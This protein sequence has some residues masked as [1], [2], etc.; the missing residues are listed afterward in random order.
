MV[1]MKGCMC[2]CVCERE[3]EREGVCVCV[4]GGVIIVFAAYRKQKSAETGMVVKI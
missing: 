3:K 1:N 2:V 4:W